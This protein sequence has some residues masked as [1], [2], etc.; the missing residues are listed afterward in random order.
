[1]LTQD[2]SIFTLQNVV[3]FVIMIATLLGAVAIIINFFESSKER[4]RKTI[5]EVMDERMTSYNQAID[6]RIDTSLLSL[7]NQTNSKVEGLERKFDEYVRSDREYKLSKDKEFA[8]I[9]V[10]LKN[11]HIEAYKND[12]RSIYYNLRETGYISD[13]DKSYVDTIYPLYTKM[14]GNSDIQAKYAEICEVYGR[15]TQ[16]R[17]DKARAIK[18]GRPLKNE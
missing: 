2:F 1:M 4:L 7:Q 9:V 16:E 3:L 10:L 8:D 6:C 14:G 11:S 5:R 17:F 12:I 18:E 13:Y 15:I